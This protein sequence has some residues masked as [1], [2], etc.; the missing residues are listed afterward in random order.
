MGVINPEKMDLEYDADD[1]KVKK[2][3]KV[4]VNK[5]NN[6]IR[7]DVIDPITELNYDP[8]TKEMD[9][10]KIDNKI[11]DDDIDKLTKEFGNLKIDSNLKD[12]KYHILNNE[13][14]ENNKNKM[15]IETAN[16]NLKNTINSILIDD[17][18]RINNL[19]LD[20]NSKIKLLENKN[21]DLIDNSNLNINNK[22]KIIQNN[23]NLIK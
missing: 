19:V 10:L 16:A 9:N 15:E 14:I 4:K 1:I 17:E 3:K 6:V 20:Y 5:N 12:K 2:P 21:K 22:N 18:K 8:I 11:K 7:T 13:L 23:N